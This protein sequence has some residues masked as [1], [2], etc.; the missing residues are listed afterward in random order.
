MLEGPRLALV[1]VELGAQ[2]PAQAQSLGLH[3]GEG[4]LPSAKSVGC[5]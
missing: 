2:P 5:S 4:A 1:G 3:L